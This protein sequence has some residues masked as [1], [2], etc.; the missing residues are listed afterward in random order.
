MPAQ[1]CAS[2]FIEQLS[3]HVHPRDGKKAFCMIEAYMDESGI[4]D[5]AHACVIAGYWGS[6]KKW[7]KFETRWKQI[8][9]DANEPTLTE[10]HSTDF[11]NA[12]G[13]RKG[14]FAQWSEQKANGFID[15]LANCIADSRVF[16]TAATLVVAEYE[17]LNRDEKMFLTG[18]NLHTA[19]Q[20]WVTSGAPKRTYFVPFRF[21]VEYPAVNCPSGLHV[22]YVFDLNKQFKT[23]ALEY[24]SLIKQNPKI[25]ARHR[26]GSIDF[27]ASD[28]AIGL[29][30]ADMLAYQTYKF[31]KVRIESGPKAPHVSGTPPLLQK[32]MT[33]L[34]D[35]SDFPFIERDGLNV[36][37]HSMP[38]NLRSPGWKPVSGL[39]R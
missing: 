7:T 37:L 35:D 33:N 39:S 6:K 5:G 26:M 18:G 10:F 19:T 17:R 22:H 21:A 13:Q 30:A 12:Q 31:G 29:Q 28:T 15:D 20:Q 16:P 8:L 2:T 4:H 3:R 14:V 9:R 25:R 32:L 11:W 34:R 1:K 36:M 24:F 27:A 38:T 23:Y